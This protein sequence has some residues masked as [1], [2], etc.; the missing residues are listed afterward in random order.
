MEIVRHTDATI[1]NGR[2]Q[3][4]RSAGLR[5]GDG[6]LRS[7]IPLAKRAGYFGLLPLP[8]AKSLKPRLAKDA[9]ASL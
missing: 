4:L 1:K 3:L 7:A 6:L 2:R 9:C 8:P 5:L